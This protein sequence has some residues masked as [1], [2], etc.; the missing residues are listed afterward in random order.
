MGGG[1]GGYSISSGE[2]GELRREVEERTRRTLA[3]SEINALLGEELARMNERD[4]QK[5]REQLE[6][7]EQ[8]LDAEIGGLDTLLFG[9]SVAKHTFVDG[10]SDID[11]LVI[12]DREELAGLSPDEVRERFGDV[13]RA[14]LAGGDV[15]DVLTGNMAVT[16]VYRDGTEIQLLP[17][18]RR[19]DE[20]QISSADGQSWKWIE[21][22]R[23]AERLTEVNQAQRRQVVPAIKLAK[24]IIAGLPEDQRLS[25]YHVEALAVAAF[26]GYNGSTT[27]REMLTHLFESA[28]RGVLS[29]APDATGQSVHIDEALGPANS[30]QRQ[31]CARALG[32]IA[33][34]MREASRAEDWRELLG[35]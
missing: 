10:L 16:L 5:V 6:K 23:F 4:T 17:A 9:G 12:L 13:L 19:G 25:G 35:Q 7:I 30:R 20:V 8:A 11:S 14:K 22:R 26:T 32:G 31:A 28:S 15:A 24:S 34:R 1:G 21:P 2:M 3:T 27:P 33:R 29:P 18:I